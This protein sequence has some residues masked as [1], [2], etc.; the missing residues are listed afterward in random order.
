M[1]LSSLCLLCLTFLGY[2]KERKEGKE[3]EHIYKIND[4]EIEKVQPCRYL[5]VHLISDLSWKLYI[6][7]ILCNANQTLG[8]PRRN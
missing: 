1:L 4:A 6:E 3:L 2:K 7:S 8:F 5:G